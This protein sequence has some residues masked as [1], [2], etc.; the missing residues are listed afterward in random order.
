MASTDALGYL[1]P[2]NRGNG[3]RIPARTNDRSFRRPPDL[4]LVRHLMQMGGRG[5]PEMSSRYKVGT[6]KQRF[7]RPPNL[8]LQAARMWC[9]VVIDCRG[10]RCK[11]PRPRPRDDGMRD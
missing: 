2:P 10:W 9:L 1:L 11:G 5:P 4:E 3:F 6:N 8:V 7:R